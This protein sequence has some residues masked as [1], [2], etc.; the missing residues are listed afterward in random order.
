MNKYNKQ[1]KGLVD[2]NVFMFEPL[3]KYNI[4]KILLY[5][6]HDVEKMGFIESMKIIKG[7]ILMMG[8]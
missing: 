6:F 2:F 5:L 1:G 4:A 3:T 8:G 7:Y